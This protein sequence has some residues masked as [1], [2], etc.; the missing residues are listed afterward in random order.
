[1]RS[2]LGVPIRVRDEVFGNLYLTDKS[3]A[4]AF[5]AIDEELVVGLA[6]AAGVAIENARLLSRVH[7]LAL[8][9]DRERIARD[10]HDTVIQ[11]LFA[12]GMVLQSTLPLVSADPQAAIARIE[13]RRR[14]PRHDDQRHPLGNLLVGAVGRRQREFAQP[15]PGGRRRIRRSA[16]LHTARRVRRSGRLV[17]GRSDRRRCA[18]HAA[19]GVEQRRPPRPRDAAPRCPWKSDRTSPSGSS[20]TVSDLPRSAQRP[21]AASP[22]WLPGRSA[23]EGPSP[24]GRGSRAAPRSSGEYPTADEACE[25]L[26]RGRSDHRVPARR[27]RDRPARAAR[28]ARGRGRHRRSSARRAPRTRPSA[29]CRPSTPTSPCS[30]CVSQEGNGVEACREIRSRHPRTACLML[31]S[32]AD[33]EALFQ[34]IMAGAAGLRAEADPLDRPRRRRAPGGRPAR[35]CSIRPSP[36]G[37]SSGC[38]AGRTRTRRSPASAAQEREVLV[39]LA[40]GSDQPPDRRAAVPRREDDQELRHVGAGQDGDGAAHRGG[41]LRRP[42][43][44]GPE[45]LTRAF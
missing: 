6:A 21:V 12:T 4:E 23:S 19:R 28:P 39:L 20:M 9:E 13:R 10:L 14:R 17:G 2:F 30:T 16:R 11:R 3:T 8:V 5:T 38:A 22:T 40:E 32:F 44:H 29:G 41:G 24:C 25:D 37:C 1:M 15:R 45:A 31:T 27:P 42:P 7:E 26:G 43:P 33:D 35:T 34:A 36:P 18:R